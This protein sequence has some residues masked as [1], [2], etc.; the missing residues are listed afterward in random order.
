MSIERKSF[1]FAVAFIVALALNL[2]CQPRS[3]FD[4]KSYN[5]HS[6]GNNTEIN[7]TQILDDKPEFQGI[8]LWSDR[9]E[10]IFGFLFR[11]RKKYV[12]FHKQKNEFIAT[13][14]S[15][16][17]KLESGASKVYRRFDG[18]YI[19]SSDSIY[20]LTEMTLLLINRSGEC[21]NFWNIPEKSS[22]PRFFSPTLSSRFFVSGNK[23]VIPVYYAFPHYEMEQIYDRE[24]IGIIHL[25][26]NHKVEFGDPVCVYPSIYREGG[27]FYTTGQI[28]SCQLI[29]G[30]EQILVSFPVDHSI[31]R[32]A[33][34]SGKK[35]EY[36]GKS[37][38]LEDFNPLASLHNL[39]HG[40]AG[41]I[42]DKDNTTVYAVKE[43]KYNDIFHLPS[44]KLFVRVALLPSE[45]KDSN[46][47]QIEYRQKGFSL[48][49]IEEV[50]LKV[51]GEFEF[52]GGE[53][54]FD[55]IMTTDSSI[56]IP[57]YG[58]LRNMVLEEFVPRPIT[59]QE[60]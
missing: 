27:Y 22:P 43:G 59:S 5:L 46:Q 1:P 4:S 23:L 45:L 9:N 34:A 51:C 35:E 31:Y 37:A 29:S 11:D 12:L 28:P 24:V 56:L 19:G 8:Q 36:S 49:F 57:R 39:K 3:S 14:D 6:L 2:G 58:D 33:L 50:S 32:V 42:L 21:V 25:N 10:S 47:N 15:V 38:Y 30:M 26:E 54:Y 41:E 13:I 53:Y 16:E 18:A 52:D 7:F 60:K 48:I 55:H 44:K 17:C 40:D 20:L